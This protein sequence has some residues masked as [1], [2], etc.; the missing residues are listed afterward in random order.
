MS[1]LQLLIEKVKEN[2]LNEDFWQGFY[3]GLSLVFISGF[4]DKTYFMNMIYVSMNP[5]WEAFGVS[6]L[7]A[8]FM[9]I[10]SIC[11][12]AI[13]PLFINRNILDWF[14]IVIFGIFGIC[15]IIQG[16]QLKSKKLIQEVNTDDNKENEDEKK[17]V[18]IKNIY[19]EEQIEDE[20]SVFNSWWKYCIAFIIGELGDKSQIATI[21]ITSKYN[22]SGV[23]CGTSLAQFLLVT[24]AVL[25]GKSVA[26]LLTNKQISIIGG[27]VFLL[28]SLIYLIDKLI[29]LDYIKISSFT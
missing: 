13:L 3:G 16:M 29:Y 18:Q 8:E 15:L 5:F 28:F 21:V 11:L 23:F 9:N 17:E 2:A 20:L 6:L 4:G 25:I 22:L 1:F 10:V 14:A 12:G 7:V 27:I 26:G 24:T 19:F